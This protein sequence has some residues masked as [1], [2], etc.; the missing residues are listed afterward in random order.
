MGVKR[1]GAYNISV[2]L[3]WNKYNWYEPNEDALK[4][5][6]E[7]TI[8]LTI[9]DW[10]ELIKNP[11]NIQKQPLVR[12]VTIED[13]IHTKPFKI[14][15]DKLA[16]GEYP[17]GTVFAFT[18]KNT[19]DGVIMTNVNAVIDKRKE[20]IGT[21]VIVKH[22]MKMEISE[23]NIHIEIL[24]LSKCPECTTEFTPINKKQ[25]YCSPRCAGRV[26]Q[27]KFAMKNKPNVSA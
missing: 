13:I 24:G 8:I 11:F 22:G 2:D 4:A 6:N 14:F 19:E 12:S 10:Q 9:N 21:D 25:I 7:A 23:R 16:G 15:V 18:L 20:A 17:Q 1:K 27:R 5:K 3:D 26:R